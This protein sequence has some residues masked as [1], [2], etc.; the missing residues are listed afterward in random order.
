MELRRFTKPCNSRRPI[1]L[2]N[3]RLSAY[4]YTYMQSHSSS[5]LTN[6]SIM[7][8]LQG[9]GGGRCNIHERF[10]RGHLRRCR[11]G[12]N[13]G[14]GHR[15]FVLLEGNQTSPVPHSVTAAIDGVD[16]GQLHLFARIQCDLVGGGVVRLKLE[17]LPKH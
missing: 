4:I 11:N 16:L 13:L 1:A 15:L 3:P 9:G 10:H 6:P 14:S 2:P 17:D 12:P 8:G 5:C 7:S